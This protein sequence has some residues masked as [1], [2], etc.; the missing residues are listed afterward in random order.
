MNAEDFKRRRDRLKKRKIRLSHERYEQ[1]LS[2]YNGLIITCPTC[3]KQGK[4]TFKQRW[5]S[6]SKRYFYCRHDNPLTWHYFGRIEDIEELLNPPKETDKQ[7]T[8][9]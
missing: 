5:G 2:K 6:D 9:G 1:L 8:L 3:G 4:L 7:A